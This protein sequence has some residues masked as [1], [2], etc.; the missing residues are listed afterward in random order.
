M[1]R[2]WNRLVNVA[3]RRKLFFN[4]VSDHKETWQAERA[5]FFGTFQIFNNM[6]TTPQIKDDFRSENLSCFG[7]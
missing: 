5:A 6:A 3:K 2:S 1:I 4:H 7:R